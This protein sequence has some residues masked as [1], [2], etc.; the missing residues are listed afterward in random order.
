MAVGGQW[1]QV[2]CFSL[3]YVRCSFGVEMLCEHR[4]GS[5]HADRTQTH[6]SNVHECVFLGFNCR[7]HLLIAFCVIWPRRRSSRRSSKMSQFTKSYACSTD[8]PVAGR[9]I[10]ETLQPL[11]SHCHPRPRRCQRIYPVS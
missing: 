6:N 2:G 8:S 4:C 11:T 5:R 3:S 10:R 1:Q 9:G 7:F